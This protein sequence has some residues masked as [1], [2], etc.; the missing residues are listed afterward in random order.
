L[1]ESAERALA[2]H[3]EYL[4][5]LGHEIRTPL[6]PL[7]YVAALLA[8]GPHPEAAMT[9]LKQTIERQVVQITRLVD[10]MLAMSAAK[11]ARLDVELRP[12][13]VADLAQQA[14]DTCRAA[15]EARRQT[16]T[17]DAD[18]PAQPARV[19]TVRMVQIIA[20]LIDNA[21]KYTPIEG[22]ID[23]SVTGSDTEVCV[24]VA[25][26]GMGISFAD[27]GALFKPFVRAPEALASDS[28]GLGIGLSVVHELVVAHRG[29]IEV[30]SEGIGQGSEFIVR[31]PR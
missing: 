10:D 30:R 28:P 5:V 17:F 23:V 1:Q 14:I 2:R 22:R 15:I 8:R 11:P 6:S 26:N 7:R 25:D 13:D 12:A 16:L 4:A 18:P 20:N 31:L 21:S 9:R 3:Q 19:D 24:R 27:A 29:T